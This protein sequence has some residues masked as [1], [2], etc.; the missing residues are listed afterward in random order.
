MP[1]LLF[2]STHLCVCVC[3]EERK[4][5]EDLEQLSFQSADKNIALIESLSVVTIFF[6]NALQH[7]INRNTYTKTIHMKM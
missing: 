5:S 7:S 1:S 4:Y 6:S 3:A 2:M